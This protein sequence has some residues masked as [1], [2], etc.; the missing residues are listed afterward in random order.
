MNI[1]DVQTSEKCDGSIIK[2]IFE[3]QAYLMIKYENIETKNGIYVPAEP[4]HIDDR[5]IQYRLKDM[6]WRFTEELCEAAE[7]L[8]VH[9][10]AFEG[11]INWQ[12]AWSTSAPV[13]HFFEELVDAVHFLTE[14][15]IIAGLDTEEIE[16][17]YIYISDDGTGILQSNLQ[18]PDGFLN[19]SSKLFFQIIRSIGLAANCL[20]NKPWKLSEMSTD[21]AKFKNCMYDTWNNF[22]E[23]WHCLGGSQEVLYSLYIK[24]H[25]VNTWR[26]DTNY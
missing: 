23:L 2:A 3:R 13:R 18:E 1:D 11:L 5:R 24:K 19:K 10:D 14:A 12:H 21:Q 17:C 9:P 22:F 20:K 16:K 15:S 7:E 4:Y 8:V 6:F 25:T 26:Q